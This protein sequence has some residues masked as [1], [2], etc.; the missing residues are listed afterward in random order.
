MAASRATLHTW[1]ALA[2][3]AAVT[4]LLLLPF[5]SAYTTSQCEPGWTEAGYGVCYRRFGEAVTFWAANTVCG[6]LGGRLAV[7]R[8]ATQSATASALCDNIGGTPNCWIGY[9]QAMNTANGWRWFGG[10]TYTYVAGDGETPGSHD[11]RTVGAGLSGWGYGTAG[12]DTYLPLCEKPGACM[13][14]LG[15]A[16]VGLG[17]SHLACGRRMSGP[18]AEMPASQFAMQDTVQ[19]SSAGCTATATFTGWLGAGD[20]VSH[21]LLTTLVRHIDA[22]GASNF[23]SVRASPRGGCCPHA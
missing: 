1:R 4:L 10:N 21:A 23:V 15:R 16:T 7:V 11:T 13:R 12:T 2:V 9:S 8:S 5:A 3:F 17:S 18:C 6:D 22:A 19:C 14:M 20:T